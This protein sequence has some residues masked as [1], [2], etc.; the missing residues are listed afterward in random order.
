MPRVLVIDDDLQ[1][2]KL[3]RSLLEREG[4]EVALADNG[5]E[6]LDA[7]GQAPAD[8]VI[9]DLIMPEK[10]GIEMILALR[11]RSPAVK[12]IAISGGARIGPETHLRMAERLGANRT[13]S[14]PVDRKALLAAIRELL[15]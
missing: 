13:F 12:I 6:G 7:Y 11:Q 10:E 5:K 3:L 15:E 4:Y 14:K 8:L 1:V 2:R 9:T